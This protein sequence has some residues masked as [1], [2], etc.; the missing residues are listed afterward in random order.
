[1][2]VSVNEGLTDWNNVTEECSRRHSFSNNGHSFF[3]VF[4]ILIQQIQKEN[5][6]GDKDAQTGSSMF[7]ANMPYA[8]YKVIRDIVLKNRKISE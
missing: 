1:V 3:V 2:A 6:V 5:T 4:D 8:T 7:G